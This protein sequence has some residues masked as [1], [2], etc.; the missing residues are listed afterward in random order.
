VLAPDDVQLPMGH[1]ETS[2]PNEHC[3][4]RGFHHRRRASVEVCA[5][6]DF[7]RRHPPTAS[8]DMGARGQGG[9]PLGLPAPPTPEILRPAQ[10]HTYIVAGRQALF[11]LLGRR[12]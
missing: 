11:P 10:R 3:E 8:R 1:L 2:L 5:R 9:R 12:C 6:H 7:L 4:L